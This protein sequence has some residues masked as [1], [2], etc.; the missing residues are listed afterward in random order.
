LACGRWLD[1]PVRR[2]RRLG[3]AAF[4]L[5]S[6]AIPL[7]EMSREVRPYPLM[8]LL[9]AVALR[10]LIA[11]AERSRWRAP[12]IGRAYAAYLLIVEL[13]LW[14][15]NLGPLWA[16]ALGL[17]LLAAV[18]RRDLRA[19]DWAWLIGGHALMLLGYAP[20]FVIL[21]DQAP[22]WI[23]STWV[24]FSWATLWPRL[25]VLYAVPG[26]QAAAAAALALLGAAALW[27]VPRGR[28]LLAM[29][30][31]LALVP[32]LLS[33]GLTLAV[34]PVFITRTMTPVAIPTLIL[35][36]IGAA[37]WRRP[38]AW[39]GGA[40]AAMLLANMA[41]VDFQA[42]RGGPMQDWYG[43]L[44]WLKR[45]M[46][47][48]DQIYAYPNEGA[49]PLVRALRDKHLIWPVRAIPGEVPALDQGGWNPTGSRGVVSLP[50]DRLRAIAE[51][52]ATRAIPTIWLL[53]LGAE[54][55]DPGDMFLEELGRGRHEVR[56]WRDGAIDI[57]GLAQGAGPIPALGS[58][59]APVR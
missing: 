18:V 41:A 7:V 14:L 44:D 3:L 25:A 23:A 48:G 8:I 40:A 10:A 53:R 42:R 56:R 46:H 49:L 15:H 34:A 13:L 54:A 4:A 19:A 58:P 21:L 1:W 24:T 9:Y 39:I 33:I 29:L 28:R 11:L 6:L 30:L 45:H 57:I 52:P 32:V 35:F 50:R 27:R 31:I 59:R 36:A 12:L 17:A 38:T 20:A 37:G 2:R 51:A 22:T 26:W 5:A 47:R 55:Y 16:A 43:T